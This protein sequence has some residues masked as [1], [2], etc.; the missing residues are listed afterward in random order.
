MSDLTLQQVAEETGLNYALVKK[1]AQ[2][3]KLRTFHEGDRLFVSEGDLAA[4]LATEVMGKAVDAAVGQ[5]AET[6]AREF[7]NAIASMPFQI[8]RAV[9]DGVPKPAKRKS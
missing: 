4:Y 9:V 8:Q 2:R 3:Q 1:H 6:V 7:R 5:P